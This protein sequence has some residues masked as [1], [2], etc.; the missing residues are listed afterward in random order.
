M[1]ELFD[2][3]LY[4]ARLKY[5]QK[6]TF[7][8]F[9]RTEIRKPWLKFLN[10]N[11]MGYLSSFC[12]WAKDFHVMVWIW[13]EIQDPVFFCGCLFKRKYQ[14]SNLLSTS[15]CHSSLLD[16]KDTICFYKRDGDAERLRNVSEELCALEALPRDEYPLKLVSVGFKLWL[17]QVQWADT[18]I[19][20]KN[21][22]RIWHI[23]KLHW[24]VIQIVKW[25]VTLT[26]Q[27]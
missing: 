8:M 5:H 7:L 16:W 27:A 3:I 11:H 26:E 12:F 9:T 22:H 14:L 4:V 1:Q 21:S 6:E 19:S 24:K 20:L 15:A 17:N 25:G 10:K 2:T 13:C 18:W 23:C